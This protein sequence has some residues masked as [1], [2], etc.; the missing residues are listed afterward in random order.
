[1]PTR[2]F[3]NRKPRSKKSRKCSVKKLKRRECCCGATVKLPCLCMIQGGECSDKYPLCPCFKL[4]RAQKRK[5][6]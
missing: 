3:P 6:G 1:M 2:R 5:N 4:Y